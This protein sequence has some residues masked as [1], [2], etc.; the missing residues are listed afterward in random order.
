MIEITALPFNRLVGLERSAIE[1][2]VLALPAD[3]KYTNH[4]GTVHASALLALAEA[5]SGE[6]LIVGLGDLGS[7]VL[8]VV[9]RIEAKF[10]KPARGAVHS[11][12]GEMGNSM[13]QLR[14]ALSAK[15]RA[16]ISVPVDVFDASGA[17]ALAASVEWFVAWNKGG[18]SADAATK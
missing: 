11:R 9:R 8:P 3:E 16:L 15:G 12:L 14:E 17:H 5:T 13:R 7:G 2:A 1:G 10:R 4:L 6:C 18:I